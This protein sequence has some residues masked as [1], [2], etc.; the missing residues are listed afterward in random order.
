MASSGET[1]APQ[2]AQPPTE[3]SLQSIIAQYLKK[4]G[5]NR[6]VEA[7]STDIAS[8]VEK[9]AVSVDLLSSATALQTILTYNAAER[10]SGSFEQ[11]FKALSVWVDRSLDQC[12]VCGVS[13]GDLKLRARSNPVLR[14]QALQ[15]PTLPRSS[16]SSTLNA[17]LT[18][19][20]VP[21]ARAV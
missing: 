20:F 3:S 15:P 12:K 6:N 5:Y 1:Q 11:S 17:S 9:M 21:L 8:S 10:F 14:S 19:R 2:P 18:R 7:I 13:T 4:K 16:G